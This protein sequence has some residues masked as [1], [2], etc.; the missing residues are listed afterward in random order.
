MKYSRNSNARNE[1]KYFISALKLDSFLISCEVAVPITDERAT[2]GRS[3]STTLT[4][5]PMLMA[6]TTST[7]TVVS[8]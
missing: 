6:T 8:C 5:T 7:T 3:M 2:F 4:T 1:E